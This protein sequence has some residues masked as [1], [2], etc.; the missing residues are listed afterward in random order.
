M[1]V[2]VVKQWTECECESPCECVGY[3]IDGI[4]SSKSKAEK[5]VKE[6]YHAFA[7]EYIVDEKC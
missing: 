1:K 7:D 2:F 5:S 6:L 4:Y 3:T